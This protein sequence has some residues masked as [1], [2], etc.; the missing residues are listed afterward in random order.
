[1]SSTSSFSW[2]SSPRHQ[3]ARGLELRRGL[4][5]PVAV[6]LAL[7]LTVIIAATTALLVGRWT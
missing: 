4:P 7:L 5:I 2:R 1:M 3:A 6:P